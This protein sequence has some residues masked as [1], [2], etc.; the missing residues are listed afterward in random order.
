[1]FFHLIC[2]R[3]HDEEGRGGGEQTGLYQRSC[4]VMP[5]C[6]FLEEKYF[7][8]SKRPNVH[9]VLEIKQGVRDWTFGPKALQ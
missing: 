7:L 5:Y 2:I 4:K 3:K 9:C 1:M 6:L 8:H